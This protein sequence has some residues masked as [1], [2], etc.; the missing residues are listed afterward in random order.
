MK[1]LRAVS[2]FIY[3][4]GLSPNMNKEEKLKVKIRMKTEKGI[5]LVELIVLVSI[6]LTLGAVALVPFIKFNSIGRGS[7]TG[8][9][10]AVDQNGIIFP[11]YDVYFKTDTSSS[12]EDL[13]CVNRNRPDLALLL[14]SLS[15]DKKQVQ[16]N[17]K[18]V[19]GIGLGLCGHTEITVVEIL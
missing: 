10:T 7:H 11:N 1:Q 6:L 14:T 9:I 19:R 12:Q 4:G 13:Y 16:I 18:G 15:K 3:N 17:Y 5:T 8:Y 2:N